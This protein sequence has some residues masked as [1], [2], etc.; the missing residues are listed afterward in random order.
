MRINKDKR[1]GR[2]LFI[3][4]GGRYE[5]SLLH[6]V[7]CGLL[8]YEYIERRRNNLDNFISGKDRYS[9][10]AVINTKNSNIK[11]I[12]DNAD[13]LDKIFDYLREE[14]HF[15]IDQ[16]AI[17]YLFDR[18][19]RSNKD[20]NRIREYILTLK[21]PYEN[22][23]GLRAGQLLLSYPSIESFTISNYIDHA[24]NIQLLLGKDAKDYIS[25]N[26]G[27]QINKLSTDTL[28]HAVNEF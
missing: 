8:Q 25:H 13:Y 5:F 27:I 23:N 9:T 16:C 14:Y 6:K 22:D 4:E 2:V 20:A 1:I 7:F 3:V 12:T 21:D 24:S 26:S 17:Y 11:D 10:I 19:P 18:D 15:P 28:I